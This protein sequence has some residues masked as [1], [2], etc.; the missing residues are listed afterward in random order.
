M[1]LKRTKWSVYKKE[2][3]CELHGEEEIC[4]I[5]NINFVQKRRRNLYE[6]EKDRCI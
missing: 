4:I 1:F 2:V 5:R 3:F 6:M